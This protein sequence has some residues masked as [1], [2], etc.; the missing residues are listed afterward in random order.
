M[1]TYTVKPGDTL[2]AI[3]RNTGT[4][5][6][7]LRDVNPSLAYPDMIRVGQVLNLPQPATP[8]SG[9][10]IEPTWQRNGRPADAPEV[11]DPVL[12]RMRCPVYFALSETESRLMP[13][14]IFCA[15]VFAETVLATMDT[16]LAETGLG[17][18][19]VGAYN[20]RR[21]R[22]VNGRPLASGR[23]SNHA[24]GTA[25]D[26]KG[27]V[28]DGRLLNVRAMQKE[29]PGLVKNITTRCEAAIQRAGRRPEIVNEGGWIHIGIWGNS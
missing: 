28:R 13:D 8:A 18:C 26:W 16:I 9:L 11:A 3:A 20:P 12:V 7:A 5:V 14:M 29:M 23:W 6:S 17:F 4:T 1:Q 21:A 22:G 15:R 25:V 19:H 24:Y 10:I 2:T 27:V